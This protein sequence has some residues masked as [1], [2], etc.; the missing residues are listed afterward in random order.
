[1]E[2]FNETKEI[3]DDLEININDDY[4]LDEGT[5]ILSDFMMFNQNIYLSKAA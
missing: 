4:L 3:E 5:Q 2:D 1:M